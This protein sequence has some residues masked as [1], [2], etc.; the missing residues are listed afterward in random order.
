MMNKLSTSGNSSSQFNTYTTSTYTLSHHQTSSLYTFVILTDPV[1]PPSKGFP[2]SRNST[3]NDSS[4]GSSSAL[5]GGGGIP[6][7]G[8][9]SL[10]GVLKQIVA[11]PWI[12]WAVRNPAMTGTTGGGLE[13]E[14]VEDEQVKPEEDESEEIGDDDD[15]MSRVRSRIAR[16][17]RGRGV[18]SDG[19]RQAIE[20]VLAQ[21][22]L[23][24][25]GFN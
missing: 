9:M 23:S 19:F 7:S 17:P 11:G 4:I 5:A 3:S 13:Y 1:Q 20:S 22:K 25:T 16:S 8:G 10:P 12:Q 21:N 2:A 14:D 24:V 18:D 6:G 15:E